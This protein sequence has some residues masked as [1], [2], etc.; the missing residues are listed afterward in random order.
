NI[1]FSKFKLSKGAKVFVYNSDQTEILGSFTHENNSDLNLLPVQ[2]IGGDEL[3]VEYQVPIDEATQ[4]EIE[5]GEVNHDFIGIFRATEPRDPV[6]T[7]HPNL[8][9]YPEDIQPGSG[10]VAL[11]INGTIYCTG[12]LVNN[13]GGDGTPYLLT[14]THCLNNDYHAAFLANRRYDLVAGR[15]IAF[16]NYQSPV[17]PKDIRGPLQMTMAS[18]DSVLISE[19]HDISLLKLKQAPPKE[20]QPWF[21]GWNA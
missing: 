10:V 8:I 13:T 16:F 14:A 4:S 12:S 5:I 18:A 11:I 3:I 19:R 2:P 21:L 9:C 15:I 7:C 20:Y 6:N 1:L 17:C